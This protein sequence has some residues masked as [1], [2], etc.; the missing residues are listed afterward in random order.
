MKIFSAVIEI[1]FRIVRQ[2]VIIVVLVLINTGRGKCFSRP[3]LV[4]YAQVLST[5]G[6]KNFVQ[7]TL[8]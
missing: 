8:P 4:R 6:L 1:N 5:L 3:L 2:K 7:A